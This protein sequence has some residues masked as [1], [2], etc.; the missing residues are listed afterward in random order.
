[1][2]TSATTSASEA[3]SATSRA[4]L[5]S[6]TQQ[7]VQY[8]NPPILSVRLPQTGFP[9]ATATS[10]PAVAD[11]PPHFIS[12]S[13]SRSPRSW[14]CAVVRHGDAT[15]FNELLGI[16]QGDVNTID[17]TTRITVL[18]LAALH[19]HDDVVLHLCKG[20]SRRDLHRTD[21]H[22]NSALMLAAGAG[23]AHVVTLLLNLGAEVDQED[24][25]GNTALMQLAKQGQAG[26]AQR[27]IDG[28]ADPAHLNHAGQNAAELAMAHGHY[29]FTAALSGFTSYAP[30]STCTSAGASTTAAP[31]SFLASST[32]TGRGDTARASLQEA[33]EAN[34]LK[35]LK[36]VLMALRQS[37]HDVP[38][39]MVRVGKLVTSDSFFADQEG[40]LLMAAAHHGH[41]KLIEVLLV[42]GAQIDQAL[43]DGWTALLF[44]AGQG[45][46]AAM[47]T[48]IAGG[49]NIDQVDADGDTALILAARN[50][51]TPL[52]EM[53]LQAGA[54]KHHKNANGDTALVEAT[55]KGQG[56]TVQA[57]LKARANPS[58]NNEERMTALMFAARDGHLEIVWMLVRAGAELN[59]F[60]VDGTTALM[61]AAAQGHSNIV[62]ML[63]T[64]GADPDM[65]DTAGFSA[66]AWA[67]SRKQDAVARSLA[68]RVTKSSAATVSSTSSAARACSPKDSRAEL[69][70]AV[71]RNDARAL[72]GLLKELHGD[73]N[74]VA[75]ELD[76]LDT[77]KSSNDLRLKSC[78]LTPLM[79]AACLGY[80][81]LIALLIEAGASVN[82]SDENGRPPLHWA[83]LYDNYACM[84]ALLKAG[85]NVD[86]FDA[87]G[88]TALMVAAM[89]GYQASMQVLL[90]AGAKVDE[91]GGEGKTALKLAAQHG[92]IRAL[93]ALIVAGATVDMTVLKGG[94]TALMWAAAQGHTAIVQ[95]LLQAGADPKLKTHLGLK[96]EHYAKDG[97][98][99]DT[100]A[101]LRM[102]AKTAKQRKDPFWKRFG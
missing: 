55:W 88:S 99:D 23:H 79:F 57:L 97:K 7:S 40:T 73:G 77:P 58:Q 66:L 56:N 9:K 25:L 31:N 63:L 42:V 81:N 75:A 52:V 10:L 38:Q 49:A 22:G 27:L 95:A 102:A 12:H 60:D 2:N 53:L 47:R 70:N 71:E 86:H 80:K 24:N 65:Q 4:Y 96:A 98:H 30:A 32:G 68:L 21:A 82:K 94:Q 5:P 67:Y 62:D 19:G 46:A 64:I 72:K 83:V 35:A 37:G 13:A 93:Q 85:A 41:A 11:N 16:G 44:A 101:L 48:L 51:Y 45:H 14:F 89:A 26:I 39:Q 28:G 87:K 61:F 100:F 59:Q 8:G 34:D 33:I 6:S 36:R 3:S 18:L 84:D 15:A 69:M 76:R 78:K 91:T 20:A 90:A 17:P 43:A 92:Q 54:E 74:D 50:G 1:M 29:F